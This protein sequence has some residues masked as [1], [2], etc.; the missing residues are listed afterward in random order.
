M[1]RSASRV[2]E[3]VLT[4]VATL[5]AIAVGFFTMN[6]RSNFALALGVS[7]CLAAIV[8]GGMRLWTLV[9]AEVAERSSEDRSTLH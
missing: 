2:I 1:D 6:V 8:L 3:I 5:A 9:T 7:I 4:V